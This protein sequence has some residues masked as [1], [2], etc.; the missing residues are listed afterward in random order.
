MVVLAPALVAVAVA[1]VTVSVFGAQAALSNMGS[2]PPRVPDHTSENFYHGVWTSWE[3]RPHVRKR[4]GL[5][6]VV[7]VLALVAEAIAM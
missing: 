4:P 1:V 3:S 7:L 5:D 6:M 2:A